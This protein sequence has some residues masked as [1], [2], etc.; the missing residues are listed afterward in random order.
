MY[1]DDLNAP[2]LN[3]L[4]AVVIMLSCLVGGVEVLFQAAEAGFIGGAEGIGWRL[5]AVQ[6]FAFSD[7]IFDWMRLNGHYSG[8]NIL[9]I[10][11]YVFIHQSLMHAVFALVFILALGKFVAEVLHP[12]AVLLIFFVSAA[13]GAA[14]YSVIL[15]AEFALIGAYPAIYGLIGAFTWLRFTHLQD[16]GE[17]GF[18]AFNLIIFFMAIALVYK[19]LIGGAN[20]WVAEL[21][22][23]C[24]GFGFAVAL[25]PDAKL[26]LKILLTQFRRR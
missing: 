8:Q 25:G 1:D 24:V 2:P 19:I 22:G 13:V 9:R 26:R 10:F 6:N 20:D 21:A 3:P 7:R 17:S 5:W 4:P 15:D 11:T 14:F 23:F 12:V 18:Q 16:E